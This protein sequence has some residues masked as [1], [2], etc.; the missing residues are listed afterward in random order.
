MVD[1][2]EQADM[3]EDVTSMMNLRRDLQNRN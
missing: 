2:A 1:A 3:D